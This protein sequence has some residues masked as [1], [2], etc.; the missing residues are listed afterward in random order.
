VWSGYIA[1]IEL[2]GPWLRSPVVIAP[3][4]YPGG[5]GGPG[6]KSQSGHFSRTYG[7]VGCDKAE[8]ETWLMS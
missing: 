3:G 2:V 7:V 5:L 1:H 8:F 4:I 6:F